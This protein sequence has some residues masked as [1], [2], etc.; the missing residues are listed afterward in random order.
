MVDAQLE[1]VCLAGGDLA[2]DAGHESRAEGSHQP[3]KYLGSR[4]MSGSSPL[5]GLA[6]QH[7]ERGNLS[8]VE[9][10]FPKFQARPV[11]AFILAVQVK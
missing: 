11:G 5:G 9:W 7:K 4:T 10:R 6:V 1:I 3:E 8:F 2:S